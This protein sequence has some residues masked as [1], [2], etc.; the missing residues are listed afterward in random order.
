MPSSSSA[1]DSFEAVT[2]SSK[3]PCRAGAPQAAA[4]NRRRVTHLMAASIAGAQLG[5]K[6]LGLE[7]LPRSPLSDRP[8]PRPVAAP[9]TQKE[10]T[11]H[12]CTNGWH[13]P[14][15]GDG[16]GWSSRLRAKISADGGDS[17]SGGSSCGR[18]E[19]S[20]DPL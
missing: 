6:T 19:P 18:G 9:G 1:S 17:A 13:V 8:Y 5:R 12:A 15:G 10:T 7:F 16:T 3:G 4:K 14:A 20:G 2:W 11:S